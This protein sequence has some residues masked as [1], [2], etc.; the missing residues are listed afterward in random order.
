MNVEENSETDDK[1]NEIAKEIP[2]QV[3][4]YN[5]AFSFLTYKLLSSH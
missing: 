2:R 5:S 1:H 3:C 4:K